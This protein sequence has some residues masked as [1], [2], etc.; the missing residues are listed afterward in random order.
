MKTLSYILLFLTLPFG[1][2]ADNASNADSTVVT[3][4]QFTKEAGDEAYDRKEYEKAIDIYE[5]VIDG[6]GA[7]YQLYY[8]LGNAY[9]RSNEIGKSILNYNRALRLNPTDEETKAN[10]EFA[11]ARIK[12]EVIE[13]NEIFFIAWFYAVVNMLGVDTWASIAVVSFIIGLCGVVLFLF[14][15]N[16]SIRYTSLVLFISAFILTAFANIAASLVYNA[17]SDGTQAIVMKEE[18][19]MMSAPG[20]STALMKIHEGR[21]VTVIDDSV[22]DWKEIELEDGTVGWIKTSDIERI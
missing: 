2:V 19:T 9:F 14:V 10:L 11:N 21:K 4:G 3:S 18:A 7:T 16:R 17:I 5:A 6:E 13:Q 8:N 20:S 12:D 22:E 1:A 15:R